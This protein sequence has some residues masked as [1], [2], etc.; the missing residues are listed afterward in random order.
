VNLDLVDPGPTAGSEPDGPADHGR[1]LGALGR[2]LRR[3][4]W[5]TVPALL[6]TLGLAYKLPAGGRTPWDAR[7]SLLIIDPTTQSAGATNPYLVGHNSL[8]TTATLLADAVKGDVA[9]RKASGQMHSEVDVTVP[10]KPPEPLLQIVVE[11]RDE[12]TTAADIATVVQLASTRLQDV[13]TEGDVSHDHLVTAQSVE[14]TAPIQQSS[15][16]LRPTLGIVAIGVSLTIWVVL[17]ADRR[18]SR[19]RTARPGRTAAGVAT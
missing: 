16:R 2:A 7:A 5:F 10:E 1:D 12:A 13:Q 6:V 8:L 19:P 14:A 17:V 15:G 9:E 11:G 18:R 3:Y 4:W